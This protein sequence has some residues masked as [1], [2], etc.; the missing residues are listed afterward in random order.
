MAEMTGKCCS[1]ENCKRPYRSKGFC[2]THFKKWRRGEMDKKPRYKIC[3]EEN[4]RGPIFR[5]GYCEQHY[6]A[7]SASKKGEDK[8]PEAPVA[9]ASSAEITSAEI[10]SDGATPE[11]AP[12]DA[13][14]EEKSE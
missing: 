12:S 8:G 9:E 5:K 4:C 7:W 3:A 11:V 14:A 6:K 13:T 1:V 10:T 2:N